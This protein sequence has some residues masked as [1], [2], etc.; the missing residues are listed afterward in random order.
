MLQLTFY[1]PKKDNMEVNIQRIEHLKVKRVCH[2]FHDGVVLTGLSQPFKKCPTKMN[3]GN[4]YGSQK[5]ITWVE[6]MRD[7]VINDPGV[8]GSCAICPFMCLIPI[9][10]GPHALGSMLVYHNDKKGA[11]FGKGKRVREIDGSVSSHVKQFQTGLASYF[12]SQYLKHKCNLHP[13]CL[14][15]RM[16]CFDGQDCVGWEHTE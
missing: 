7:V 13:K 8:K 4:Y 6:M 10:E 3:D 1:G 9:V 5:T 2:L 11:P 16:S 15:T 12:W 14:D